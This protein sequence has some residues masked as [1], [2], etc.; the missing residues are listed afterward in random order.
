MI[1]SLG[2]QKILHNDF[3]TGV[4]LFLLLGP[5]GLARGAGC[6]ILRSEPE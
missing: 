1:P 6:D 4:G 2:S 5:M 3:F